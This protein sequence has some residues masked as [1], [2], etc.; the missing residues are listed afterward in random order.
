MPNEPEKQK[1]NKPKIEPVGKFRAM[2]DRFLSGI[3]EQP[4]S[5]I[6]DIGGMSPASHLYNML[7]KGEEPLAAI[8]GGPAQAGLFGLSGGIASKN[9]A[10][11]SI[12]KNSIGTARDIINPKAIEIMN[13]MYKESNPISKG[14]Q[15]I[16]SKTERSVNVGPTDINNLIEFM[17]KKHAIK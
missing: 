16:G 4:A 1:P 14:I 6:L 2:T 5:R 8:G 15:S 7:I 17:S 10:M 3:R 11:R 13:A 12:V 9:P